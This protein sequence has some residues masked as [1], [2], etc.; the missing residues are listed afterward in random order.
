M[1]RPAW[2]DVTK[3][4]NS[5]N[6]VL[7]GGSRQFPTQA[8]LCATQ[9]LPFHKASPGLAVT[10][11]AKHTALSKGRSITTTPQYLISDLLAQPDTLIQGEA[12]HQLCGQ[13]M[14]A[15][16][17]IHDFGDVKEGVIFQQLPRG[18]RKGRKTFRARRA[19]SPSATPHTAH[20][21]SSAKVEKG[22]QPVAALSHPAFTQKQSGPHC[23]GR[24]GGVNCCKS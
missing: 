21:G 2:R 18:K 24:T 3:L 23:T 8:L 14:L 11:Q 19:A 4:P 17:L 16:Q 13:D 9:G 6:S 20:G 22:C 12:R 5:L 7:P 15:A 1:P 10:R